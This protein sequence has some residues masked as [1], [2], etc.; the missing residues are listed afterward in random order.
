LVEVNEQTLKADD[1]VL[2]FDEPCFIL[3]ES[4]GDLWK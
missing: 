3:N 1:V 4:W 2:E